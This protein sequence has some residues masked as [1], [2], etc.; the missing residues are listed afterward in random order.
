MFERILLPVD[1]SPFAE[2]AFPAAIA[3]AERVGGE[4]RLLSVRPHLWADEAEA[5]ERALDQEAWAYLADAAARVRAMTS[6][7]VSSDMRRGGFRITFSSLP[8]ARMFVNFFSFTGF[9]AKSLSR[10]FSPTIIPS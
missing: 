10:L 1:G 9:T 4:I 7:P 8:A 3:F 5:L 2:A 6:V